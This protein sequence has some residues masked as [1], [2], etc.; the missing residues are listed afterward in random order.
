MEPRQE[1]DV[2]FT[3]CYKLKAMTVFQCSSL[4]LQIKRFRRVAISVV[5][6]TLATAI[7][8]TYAILLL[9][10]WNEVSSCSY[11]IGRNST[12][13]PLSSLISS[14]ELRYIW[15]SN[16]STQIARDDPRYLNYVRSFVTRP[17]VGLSRRLDDKT[18]RKHFSQAGLFEPTLE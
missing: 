7:L 3:S 18:G 16:G 13:Q 15:N 2:T 12:A 14:E 17:E 10:Q 4:S 5:L 8:T 1:N 9:R 6:G 11:V